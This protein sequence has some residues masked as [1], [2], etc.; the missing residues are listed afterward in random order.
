MPIGSLQ[1]GRF[2]RLVGRAAQRACLDRLVGGLRSGQGQ[3]LMI[4]GE[5]G[6]GKSALLGYLM[7][8][9]GDLTVLATRGIESEAALAYAGLGDLLRPLQNLF[10]TL[11]TP[12][13][14]A[15]RTA[16]ALE[17]AAAEFSRYAVCLG[18]L[19]ALT[20]EAER[21]A[22]LVV[23]DDA[24][25]LDQPSL[26][27]LLFAARRIQ[28]DAVSVVLAVR[29]ASAADVEDAAI[30]IMPV[31]GLSPAET[32]ELLG[33]LRTDPIAP[34]VADELWRATRGNPLAVTDVCARLS[35]AQLA[36][37]ELLG[38]RLPLSADLQSSFAA[39]LTPL[40][41]QTRTALLVAALCAADTDALAP[42]LDALGVDA[43][44]LDQAETAGLIAYENCRLVFVHP[45]M[46]SAIHREAPGW[47]RRQA[48]DALAAT[49]S[50]EARA[51][52]RA[53]GAAGPDEEVAAELEAAGGWARGR[54]GYAA[55]SR[56]LHRAAELTEPGAERARRLAA[57]AADAQLAGHAAAAAQWLDQAWTMTSDP[58][59]LADIDLARG[60]LLTQRGTP[61]I[62]QQ[63]LLGAASAVEQ[64]DPLRAA[65]LMCEA[66]YPSL[67]EGRVADSVRYARRAVQL[68]GV[69]GDD[70]ARRDAR[71][72]LAQ[73]LTIGGRTAQARRL[74]IA[75][76]RYVDALDPTGSEH[77]VALLALCWAWLE[78][79][80]MATALIER[81][82]GAARRSGA[83]G[84]LV[85]ALSFQC[86]IGRCTGDWAA[87]YAVAEESLHLAREIRDVSNVGFALTCLARFDAVQ[88][89]GDLLHERLAEARK[90]SG[91][92]GT[93]GL[94]LF[95]ASARGLFH[96]TDGAPDEA[97]TCLET[98][99]DFSD[100]MGIDNPNIVGWEADLVEAY[101]R[102]G[103]P[104]DVRA[105]LRTLEEKARVTGL[106]RPRAAA[107]RSRGL[108]AST[109]TEAE[110]HFRSALSL[111][112]ECP[113]PFEQA[114]T[115]LAFGE[116]LRRRQRR[117]EARPFLRDALEVF[118]RL[119]AEPYARRAAAELEATGAH[120]SPSGLVNGVQR[121]TPQE[122]QVARAVADGMSNPE[123]AAALFI[124]RKTVEAHLSSAYRK[125]GVHS[126]TQLVRHV[127]E[128][129]RPWV[130]TAEG[131]GPA[132][133]PR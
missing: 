6:T 47:A 120:P 57:A 60:R 15:L 29:D 27:A 77:K 46:R 93:G 66:I 13:A 20:T 9:A 23:V 35:A 121:L 59:L 61:S 111:H 131:S 52:Y 76:R 10:A 78:D 8:R 101:W 53:A 31:P 67:T 40:A 48:Y 21:R 106:S 104:D 24:H 123:V 90:L 34:M 72:H 130:V 44:A 128:A 28:A 39:R 81:V 97:I 118:R 16:L 92:L 42:A 7:R 100:R 32:A 113:Q 75:A 99:R 25:W 49:G 88:G 117:A 3:A 5:A 132:D 105:Q 18:T 54:T 41:P 95:E 11:P 73:A 87:A 68:A 74:L 22:V 65:R 98:V 79:Y 112:A 30:E 122:L 55:A 36:G 94:L 58:L 110:T 129:A 89:R 64:A 125:L 107:A 103:R 116:V 115:A 50:G 80:G 126:R 86:E 133:R 84:A 96:L 108:L 43:T 114:R 33:R 4:T 17:Q 38:D 83:L 91:P 51:W 19:T 14:A 37:R 127:V 1:Q 102:A 12:Q 63:V 71:T 45:L 124:S 62:A 85:R 69:A 119:G 56:A 2:Q 26:T 82:V 70:D 109:P